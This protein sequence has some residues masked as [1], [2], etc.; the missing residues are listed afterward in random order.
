MFFFF[1]N[2]ALVRTKRPS[3][4]SPTSC[5]PGTSSYNAVDYFIPPLLSLHR[6]TTAHGN[7]SL[8]FAIFR[9]EKYW[10]VSPL[11]SLYCYRVMTSA[12]IYFT[13]FEKCSNHTIRTYFIIS[14]GSE[15]LLVAKDTHTKSS[16]EKRKA[17]VYA[18]F[19]FK[20]RRQC[21]AMNGKYL[22][23]SWQYFVRAYFHFSRYCNGTWLL[24]V[25]ATAGLQRYVSSKPCWTWLSTSVQPRT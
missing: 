14:E 20:V 17:S 2:L 4:F 11:L 22:L 1:L 5:N 19:S 3:S 25:D 13:I 23:S 6:V 12:L 18:F 15:K 21:R 8:L 24:S 9:T 10:I 16:S 7:S